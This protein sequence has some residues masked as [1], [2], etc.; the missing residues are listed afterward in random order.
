[1]RFLF[2]LSRYLSIHMIKY[3]EHFSGYDDDDD[4]YDYN[5]DACNLLFG[6]PK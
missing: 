1:M 3:L 6:E 2:T 5:V 4:D